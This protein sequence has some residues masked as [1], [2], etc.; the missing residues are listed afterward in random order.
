MPLSPGIGG[1]LPFQ[2]QSSPNLWASPY[3]TY[4]L[5]HPPPMFERA[6]R[7]PERLSELPRV[8]QTGFELHSKPSISPQSLSSDRARPGSQGGGSAGFERSPVH[9]LSCPVQLLSWSW[10]FA[11]GS[12]PPPAQSVLSPGWPIAS[13]LWILEGGGREG[14]GT[15]APWGRGG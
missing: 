14:D 2:W 12:L 7:G 15:P 1:D 13:L 3:L 5:E 10:P 8:P 6:N 11:L 9:L 4:I